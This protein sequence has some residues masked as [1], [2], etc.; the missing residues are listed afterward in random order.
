MVHALDVGGATTPEAG[1]FEAV[2]AEPGPW[3]GAFD[4]PFGLPRAFVESLALGSTC[5]QVDA[6]VA[7]G[8]GMVPA[9][10]RGG[11][12]AQQGLGAV[13][14]G[15]HKGHVARVV[16]AEDVGRGQQVERMGFDP[17]QWGERRLRR[18]QGPA[19]RAEA[20]QFLAEL[21]RGG[22]GQVFVADLFD[23]ATVSTDT[24]LFHS[25]QPGDK[26]LTLSVSGTLYFQ[27]TASAPSA[28]SVP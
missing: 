9:L 4:F 24:G 22:A 13:D 25:P 7:P 27:T 28:R 14:A 15:Q 1:G 10:E 6:A 23:I 11:G 12:R 26:G 18:P 3:Y 16:L 5:A 19:T 20:A 17:G 2:L 21:G 8:A